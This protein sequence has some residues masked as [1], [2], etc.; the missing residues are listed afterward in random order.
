MARSTKTNSTHSHPPPWL[1]RRP[2]DLKLPPLHIKITP[3]S[4]SDEKNDSPTPQQQVANEDIERDNAHDEV[5]TTISSKNA[6]NTQAWIQVGVNHLVMMNS[7]GLIQSFGIFQ[8]PY[9][10][11]LNSTPSTVAWIGSVHIFLVYFLGAFTGWILDRGYYRYSMALG[12]ALQIIGLVVAGFSRTVGMTFVFHGL[13]QGIG[14]GL[15]FCPAVTTTAVYFKNSKLRMV[16]L[17]IA[18]CGASTGGMLFPGIARHTINTLG[19]N[20]TLWI[21]CGV[22]CFN[23][24]LI[25]GLARTGSKVKSPASTHS[26]NQ[27]YGIWHVFKKPS[28]T[29]YVIA[30]FFIFAGLWIPFFYTREYSSKAL[31]ITK[32]QS[33][34]VLIILNAAGIPGRMIPAFLVDLYLG[35]INTYIVTLLLSGVTLLL[36]P[37]VSSMSAMY[38]WS[39]A[40]G[41][42]AGGVSSLLQAGIASLNDE[43]EKTG[44][45]IGMA[46]SVVAFAS[47][48]GGPVGGEL[49]QVAEATRGH[50]GRA[51]LYMMLFT[52]GIML[53]GCGMLIVARIAKTGQKFR[54][55]V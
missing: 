30:M 7:F 16:A 28:Y 48:L 4:S 9:E 51:Y 15:M 10:V 5:G 52:A 47:L 40:Y 22:V 54:V 11:M 32:S 38:P 23:S 49:I 27:N 55:K 39:F 36:W 35:T 17:G 42:C 50:G 12:S 21:M 45:E 34:I 8:L 3:P 1:S 44:T 46:F 2:E 13:F 37:L 18:G 41:F 29:L 20:Y 43:P 24:I 6:T 31:H 25:Q 26:S 19:L 53:L 33:F 14:H